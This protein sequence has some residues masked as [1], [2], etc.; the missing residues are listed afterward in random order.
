MN[1]EEFIRASAAN[2]LSKTQT[3]KAL[4]MCREYFW[5]ILKCWPDIV[6]AKRGKTL[7]N[8]IGNAN[9]PKG[10][11]EKMLAALDRARTARR[12]NHLYTWQGRT[13]TVKELAVFAKA[14]ERT[15]HRRLKEGKSVDDAFGLPPNKT[16]PKTGLRTLVRVPNS[17]I[18]REG[19]HH[20]E[21]SG[22]QP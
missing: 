1:T 7:G 6:W 11:S 15:I 18:T 14:S 5:E 9:R 22:S 17:Y 13:G 12:D 3:M 8:K 2:G 19:L 4:G 16:P 20:E 10:A 21:E